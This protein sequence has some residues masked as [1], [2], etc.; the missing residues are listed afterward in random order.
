MFRKAIT[1]PE[2]ST[3]SPASFRRG[4]KNAGNNTSEN[5]KSPK[6]TTKVHSRDL[7]NL[8]EIGKRGLEDRWRFL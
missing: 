7:T 5:F 8:T 4:L 3:S 1:S 2:R 6:A